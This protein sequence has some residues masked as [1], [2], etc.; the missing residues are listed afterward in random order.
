MSIMKKYKFIDDLTSDVLFE[1]Y[2]KDLKE[3]F[4]N[5]AEAM[6]SIICK[7]DK[8]KQEKTEE[9]VIKGEKLEDTFWNWLSGLIALVD[10]E[11]MFFSKFEIEE[12]DETH[13]KAK[14]H[15]QEI[16]PELGETVVKS[17]TNYKYEVKKTDKG[18]KAVVS[19][20]I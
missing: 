18:Y 2:G 16:Q 20:D 5:A 7:I 1:A 6:F 11:E 4:S 9:F 14:L 19:L 17:L 8:I 10:T 12:I 15:G 3:L 13:V